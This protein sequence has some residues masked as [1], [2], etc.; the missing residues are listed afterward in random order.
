LADWSSGGYAADL[1]YNAISSIAATGASHMAIVITGYQNTKSS[2]EV[3]LDPIR[4]PVRSAVRQAI[5]W[6]QAQ[7]MEIVL[8]LHILAKDGSWSADL[9]PSLPEVWFASY[10]DFLLPWADMA[11]LVGAPQLI[12][13]TEL[14]KTMEHQQ[15]WQEMINKVKSVYKGQ[16]TYAASWDEVF[17]VPF[18]NE[19]DYVGVDFYFPV[20]NR[21]DPGR[22]E[23]LAGWQPWLQKLEL[24]HKQTGRDIMFTEIGYRSIDGAGMN[25]YQF[26]N[27]G[28][29]DL[30]EQA[31]LYW[32]AMQSTSN[33][34]WLKGMFWWNWLADG[35]GGKTNRDYTPFTKPAE[36]VLTN[37]WNNE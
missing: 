22:L 2:N 30:Q 34:D 9:T 28:T 3:F 6:A 18:W 13:G 14:G 24:L 1:S 16:L 21:K 32:A 7:G 31:D 20:A 37:F 8:K 17:K 15:L 10:F 35:S 19:L 12:V 36:S 4:T 29:L 27:H 5:S 33:I 26:E 25:P 23:I 11:E